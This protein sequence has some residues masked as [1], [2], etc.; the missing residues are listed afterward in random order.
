MNRRFYLFKRGN[1]F[2]V[3]FKNPKTRKLT[4]A[5]STGE[6]DRDRANYIVQKWLDE[7]F[8]D[9]RKIEQLLTFDYLLS[10]FK[11]IDLTTADAKRI[12]DHLK[13]CGLI[14]A[15]SINSESDDQNIKTFLTTF[16][17]Y[18]SSPYVREKLAHGHSIGKRHCIEMT[19]SIKRYWIPYFGDK[20]I[21]DLNK[22]D[23]KTFSLYLSEERKLAAKTI[24]NI[25]S[26]GTV[27]LTWAFKNEIINKN[28]TQ[29]LIKFSGEQKKR[30]ILSDKEIEK[31]FTLGDWRTNEAAKLGSL[32]AC[33]TG[34]RA[35]EVVGLQI[36]N[37]GKD[38]LFVKHSFSW[39][40]GLKSTKTGEEREIPILPETREKLLSLAHK[41]PNGWG[42]SSFIFWSVES[43]EK[44]MR[45][46]TLSTRLNHALESIGISNNERKSRGICFHSWRHYFARKMTDV[47][48]ER[49]ARLTGHATSEMLQHYADHRNESDFKKAAEAT[50]QVF[51]HIH[52]FKERKA[53]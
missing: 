3:Q 21:H 42:P 52:D 49:T 12:T 4:T 27:A 39:T 7:G 36:Q 15:V 33:Q 48:E 13:N 34:L 18:E 44:P 43:S 10:E 53:Q 32:L 46:E 11:K 9:E 23:I 45:T 38:R 31:L 2:Y 28:P 41:N 17:N 50:T 26:A 35:G 30:G 40:D 16:W 24:N 37:V 22:T 29:G 8:P 47:L 5:K 6:R 51:G 25:M 20:S 14:K 1:I 19:A